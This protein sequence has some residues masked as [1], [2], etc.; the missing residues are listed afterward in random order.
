[1][2]DKA[3]ERET[4]LRWDEDGP[5]ATAYTASPRQAERWR[6]K[7]WSVT[8]FRHQTGTIPGGWQAEIPI[9]AVRFARLVDGKMP[10]GAP[11][12]TM[13]IP[14]RRPRSNTEVS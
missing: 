6:K 2:S 4:I 11:R 7:G 12:A 1:M 5:L 10:K 3:A 14:P 8:E 13:P 9:R